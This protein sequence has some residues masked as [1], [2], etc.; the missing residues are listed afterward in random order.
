MAEALRVAPDDRER[1]RQAIARGSHDRL[2]APADANPGPQ[3]AVLDRRV[4]RCARDRR[5]RG[6]VPRH[7]SGLAQLGEEPQPVLEQFLIARQVEAEERV[8]LGER[9]AAEDDLGA[10]VR[11]GVDGREALKDAHRVVGA[12]YGDRRSE[13]DARRP[14]GDRAQHDLGRGNREVAPVMFAD[15]K[16]MQPDLVGEHRLGHDVAQHVR[17]GMKRSVARGGQIA[18]SVEPDSTVS[19]M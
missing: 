7:R 15:A 17:R 8:R 12:E 3:R 6:P 1:E 18:E 5:A 9:A 2:R 16:R 4:H 19:V 10:A 13:Q 11:Q 14:A